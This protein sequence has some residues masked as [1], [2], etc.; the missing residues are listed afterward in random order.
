MSAVED[1]DD[2]VCNGQTLWTTHANVAN[3]IT[4]TVHFTPVPTLC[5]S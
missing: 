5:V 4:V 2:L 3:S 1:G